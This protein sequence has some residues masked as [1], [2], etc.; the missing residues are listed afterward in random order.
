MHERANEQM[1]SISVEFADGEVEVDLDDTQ[2]V[3]R[4]ST[5]AYHVIR[6][7]RSFVV[8][9]E[10]TGTSSYR[11]TLNGNDAEAHIRTAKDRLL[12]RYGVSAAASTGEATVKAPMP[13][14][15]L[16]ILVD[17][18]DVVARGD[19]LVVLEAMKMENELTAPIDGRI[20]KIGRAHV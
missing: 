8:A 5:S 10:P 17:E 15:V 4:L 12:E 18:G 9:V 3:K 11:V 2:T 6:G 7:N 16:R 1:A 19:G 13:G 20:Q 14:L